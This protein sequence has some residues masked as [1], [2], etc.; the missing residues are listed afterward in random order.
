MN[1]A[2]EGAHRP[3]LLSSDRPLADPSEDILGHAPFAKALAASIVRE[4]PPDGLVLGIYGP[5]GSG[6][7]TALNF[8]IHYLSELGG[9]DPPIVLRFNPWWF[10][11][12]E[13]LVRRYF[14]LFER[15]VFD[16]RSRRKKLKTT[17]AT[18]A[19]VFG[20]GASELGVPGGKAIARAVEKAVDAGRQADVVGLK[21]ELVAELAKAALRIVVIIDDIDRLLADDVRTLFR[22]VKAVADF[23]N[24]TYVLAFD[25]KVTAGALETLHPGGGES[26]LEK[27]VQ[28]PFELPP[29]DAEQLRTML[30]RQLDRIIEDV[31]RSEFDQQRFGNSYIDC[32]K[33]FVTKPRDVVRLVNT[34]SVTFPAVRGEVDPV[35]FISIEAIRLFAPRA[36][37]II[38]ENPDR[39]AGTFFSGSSAQELD[40][41]RRFHM[42][43]MA[44]LGPQ[45]ETIKAAIRR[46]FP[47]L[48]ALWSNTHHGSESWRRDRRLCSPEI[49]PVYFRGSVPPDSVSRADFDS[50]MAVADNAKLFGQRLNAIGGQTRPDGTA[51]ARAVLDLLNDEVR[52]R[53]GPLSY[54]AP[55]LQALLQVGD[56]LVERDAERGGFDIGVRRWIGFVV[57]NLLSRMSED[58]RDKVLQTAAREGC[59][60][61]VI[62]DFVAGASADHGRHDARKKPDHDPEL[63]PLDL[64]VQLE[65]TVARRIEDAARSGRLVAHKHSLRLLYLWRLFGDP[66]TVARWVQAWCEDDQQ[67]LQLLPQFLGQ[68]RSWGLSDHA[69]KVRQRANVDCLK[70]FFD[71]DQLRARIELIRAKDGLSEYHRDLLD[72]VGGALSAA[73]TT[74]DDDDDDD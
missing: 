69:V 41:H 36:Y 20:A 7:S 3:R 66:A 60:L 68:E 33:P 54:A 31:P 53:E 74:N 55:M 73:S 52:R 6:K 2:T 50:L 37:S 47:R 1:A 32:V 58:E 12:H 67:L 17:L 35:D 57:D 64:V 61:G 70:D 15:A 27:I 23:P 28:V 14:E 51:R 46:L 26:Y 9:D 59:A 39:F 8:F 25:R 42:A 19:N 13:D 48:D 11:G 40:E 30:F 71:A 18:F 56:E 65:Q 62:A 5:W 16:A 38:R 21:N 24:V 44:P 63:L 49:F 45:A 43:W 22:L 10:S 72:V 29:A 34:L 4:C